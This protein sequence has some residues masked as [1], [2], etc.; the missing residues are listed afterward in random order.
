MVQ[1]HITWQ[2]HHLFWP[3]RE[4]GRSSEWTRRRCPWVIGWLHLHL[5]LSLHALDEITENTLTKAQEERRQAMWTTFPE[6]YF[7]LLSFQ[8]GSI[9]DLG[10]KSIRIQ[11][12]QEFL[13]R[14]GPKEISDQNFQSDA[15]QIFRFKYFNIG[16]W[17]QRDCLNYFWIKRQLSLMWMKWIIMVLKRRDTWG[18]LRETE[19]CWGVP[20]LSKNVPCLR[21][22]MFLDN[23]LD[24]NH[25]L[26]T[27]AIMI[28]RFEIIFT[29]LH[30]AD[31]IQLGYWP[32]I[33]VF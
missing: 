25:S 5:H 19:A 8:S 13:Y 18:S 30:F 11:R 4:A 7:R 29:H 31:Y 32:I 28:G 15:C 33:I 6:A 14:K 1:R 12:S 20:I 9:S 3:T 2:S 10:I 17:V 16:I 26:V 27:N 21:R 22:N 24:I 23:S